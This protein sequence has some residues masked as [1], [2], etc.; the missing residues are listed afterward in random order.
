MA[1]EGHNDMETES[2][3]A[4]P[5]EEN[6]PPLVVPK[7]EANSVAYPTSLPPS[8]DVRA[9]C[10]SPDSDAEGINGAGDRASDTENVQNEEAEVQDILNQV[11]DMLDDDEARDSEPETENSYMPA[12]DSVDVSYGNLPGLLTSSESEANSSFEEGTDPAL[13]SP[14]SSTPACTEPAPVTMAEFAFRCTTPL[15]RNQSASTPRFEN[16]SR[17]IVQLTGTPLGDFEIQPRRRINLDAINPRNIST[18]FPPGVQ[19]S[20]GPIQELPTQPLMLVH[21]HWIDQEVPDNSVNTDNTVEENQDDWYSARTTMSGS[22][23]NDDGN[24]DLVIGPRG[25][26]TLGV[27][28]I[29]SGGIKIDAFLRPFNLQRP[30]LLHKDANQNSEWQEELR[31]L[32]LLCLSPS[33]WHL[34]LHQNEGRTSRTAILLGTEHEDILPLRCSSLHSETGIFA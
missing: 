11:R 3:P 2:T 25:G 30:G 15:S 12:D 27:G 16:I 33:T 5:R 8:F 19:A 18:E 32:F 6:T 14:R 4:V 1:T 21:A 22:D 20:P 24:D 29:P 13:A 7:S 26:A 9:Y 31:L 10:F 28:E 17:E 34:Q 23:S